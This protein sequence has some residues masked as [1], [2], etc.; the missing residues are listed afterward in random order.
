MSDLQATP[1]AVPGAPPARLWALTLIAIAAGSALIPI[2]STMLAVAL[3]SI[4]RDLQ[5]AAATVS[6]L[7]TLYLGAVALAMPLA[8]SLGDRLGYRRMYLFGVAGFAITSLVA[9]L[10]QNFQLLVVSRVLQAASGAS[11][12]AN[13]ASLIRAMAPEDRR[14][15][16]YGFYDM[17]ISTSAAVGPF[18]GGLLVGGFGW[19]SLFF[20]AVPVGVVSGLVVAAVVPPTGRPRQP[21]PPLDIL[22]LGLV[23]AVLLALIVALFEGR[24]GGRWVWPAAAF[25]LLLGLLVRRE[26]R[27]PAP[28]VD[29][30]LFT[31][32][33]F[34]AAVA[35]VLGATV[36]LHAS[37]VLIPILTQTVLRASPA[38]SGG[39]LLMLSG[40]GAVVAPIGGR[41]SDRVGRRLPAVVGSALMT[42]GL[43]VLWR[44]TDGMTLIGLSAALAL[45][46]VGSGFGGSSRQAAAIESV[47]GHATGM[48]AGT[49]YTGRYVGGVLGASLAG[50]VLAGGVS[51]ASVAGGFGLLAAVGIAVTLVSFGLR[52]RQ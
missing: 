50:V 23:A 15:G 52:G 48:A 2:N 33:S 8:G 31:V 27:T 20:V 42:L 41:L 30:R 11:I 34:A 28:A 10:A 49:Y 7:V 51:A 19:R 37:L 25:P 24:S 5:V 45:V 29:V 44:I 1:A 46:G 47:P 9:A 39:V 35:A 22:G 36:I 14:G 17:L 3:P 6:W 26:L 40:L 21:H 16:S 12:T 38:A 4:M 32:R 43:A 13:A 18:I